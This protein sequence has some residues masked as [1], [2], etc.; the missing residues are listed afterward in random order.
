MYVPSSPV[1]N[2][3]ATA[4]QDA[5]IAMSTAHALFGA[6]QDKG[7]RRLHCAGPCTRDLARERQAPAD[8]L[9]VLLQLSDAGEALD[10]LLEVHELLAEL[11]LDLHRELAGAVQ[12]LGHLDK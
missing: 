3:C 7:N 10:A 11:L 2:S 4:R 1:E 5:P 6:R 8:G 9:H 12:E